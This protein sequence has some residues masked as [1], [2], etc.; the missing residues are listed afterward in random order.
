M[1]GY[2]LARGCI[3]HAIC[4]MAPLSKARPGYATALRCSIGRFSIAGHLFRASVALKGSLA[5]I[6]CRT[7]AQLSSLRTWIVS[8]HI[9]PHKCPDKG[10]TPAT[11]P[12]SRMASDSAAQGV[13]S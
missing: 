12:Q 10:S 11:V 6:S 4:G 3:L 2:L 7:S 8:A 1:T 9:Q 13:V 5:R